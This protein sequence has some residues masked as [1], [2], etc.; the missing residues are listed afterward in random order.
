MPPPGIEPGSRASRLSVRDV[1]HLEEMFDIACADALQLMT[2][3][4]DKDFLI[5]RRE[6]GHRGQMG[7]I[8]TAL[9][10][11]DRMNH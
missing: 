1:N 4:E 7:V 10:T 6:K 11:K 9:Y 5:A 8:D 3:Q 2:I